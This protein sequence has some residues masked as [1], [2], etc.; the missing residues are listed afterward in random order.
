MIRNIYNTIRKRIGGISPEQLTIE[1][2]IKQGMKVGENCHGLGASTIDYA[3]CWLIEIGDNVTF[4]PQVYLLAHDASTKRYLDYTKISKVKIEDNVFIGA[5]ALIMP[6]V[7]I[8]KDSIIAAG[9]VVTKSVPAG[10]VVGGNPAKIMTNTKNYIA[11]HNNFIRNSILYDTNWTI[12]GNISN[13]MC[14]KMNQEMGDQWAY[15]K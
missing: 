6:G 5:R 11:K 8:G 1:A 15:V 9:S 13:E 14:E 10:S 7:T 3:H 2:C 12:G 4:A